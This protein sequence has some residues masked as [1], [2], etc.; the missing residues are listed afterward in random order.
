MPFVLTLN[1][2]MVSTTRFLPLLNAFRFRLSN[3]LRYLRPRSILKPLLSMKGQN[4]NRGPQK[5]NFFTTLV[6][7]MIHA[8]SVVKKVH[9][10]STS[11]GPHKLSRL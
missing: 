9:F 11:M 6:E 10:S 1:E 7:A 8:T 4:R 3:D 2:I 5:M